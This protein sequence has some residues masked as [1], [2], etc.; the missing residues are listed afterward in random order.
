MASEVRAL[1]KN[2]RISPQK[3]RLV[4]DQIRGVAAERAVAMLALSPKKAARLLEKVL[5][6]AIANAEQNNG[7]DR[8]I[9]WLFPVCMLMREQY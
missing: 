4:A 1:S 9:I 7:L 2:M 6:S 3:A 5:K 8:L